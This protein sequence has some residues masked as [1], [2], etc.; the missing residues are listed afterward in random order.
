MC[1]QRSWWRDEEGVAEFCRTNVKNMFFKDFQ[2]NHPGPYQEKIEKIKRH[3]GK[4]F[5]EDGGHFKR[6]L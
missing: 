2:T 6:W 5:T 4:M 3:K 1:S